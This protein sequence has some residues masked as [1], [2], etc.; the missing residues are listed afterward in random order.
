SCRLSSSG[1]ISLSTSLFD[2]LA[3]GKQVPQPRPPFPDFAE[4]L[5]IPAAKSAPVVAV[6]AAATDW[7]SSGPKPSR[8]LYAFSTV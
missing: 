2:K 6:H 8:A 7:H 4:S 1:G 5:R 3:D